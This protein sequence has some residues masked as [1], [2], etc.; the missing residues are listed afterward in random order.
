MKI[1][2]IQN[3]NTQYKTTLKKA[4]APLS[5][6]SSPQQQNSLSN[7]YYMPLNP[8]FNGLRFETNV[9][10]KVLG[11]N[12]Q[13]LGLYTP[14][15]NFIDFAKVGLEKLSKEPL[16]IV[17]A[18]AAEIIAYRF[19]LAL[20][21]SYAEGSESGSQWGS[22]YNPNNMT[23]PLAIGNSLT[24]KSAKKIF[25]NNLKFLQNPKYGKSLD[26][27]ITDKDGNLIINAIVFD[28][29]TTG[30]DIRDAKIVQ[31]ATSKIENGKVIKEA[32]VNQLINPEIPIPLEATAVHGI[33][34]SMVKDAP[35]MKDYIEG[36]LKNTINKENG[37]IV[38]Y[39]SKYDIPL[40]NREVREYNV[41]TNK[42]LKE[43]QMAKVLDPFILIQ[44]IHPFIGT[45][46]K[47]GVQYNWLFCKEMENAHDA[48][49]DVNGTVDVL[50]Y[51]LYYLSEHRKDKSVP[52]TLRE[53]LLFQNGETAIE[54]I[55]LPINE[56]KGFNKNVKF[57]Q[58]YRLEPLDVTNYFLKYK[59]SK[60]VITEIT[61]EIGEVNA[62]K[63][64]GEGFVN[65][66][67]AAKYKGHPLMAA[68]TQNIPDSPKAKSLKY[69]L[70]QNMREVLGFAKL[71]GYNGK[72]KE[73]ITDFI[74]EKSKMYL[75][76]DIKPIW[77]K[78]VN[79]ADMAKGNDLPDDAIAQKVMKEREEV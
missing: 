35:T 53:V 49:A 34:D 5:V 9:I 41:E 69:V 52:L 48:M 31:I 28:T 38:A 57:D 77:I 22:R 78:N 16:N 42:Q 23:S 10:Q 26:K 65:E 74:M 68:E 66:E 47:L 46:K 56:T 61:P 11:K 67:I 37:V 63:L 76:N 51:C 45:K 71:E 30:T 13:G 14:D 4:Q 73:E 19:A 21:E 62:K 55:A 32:N 27:P 75:N 8:R 59:L 64:L 60:K 2:P 7:V 33:T 43:R 50:K 58:S 12:Y 70:E 79:P 40:L 39:N 6:I 18:T 24:S 17:K 54:N 44:R 36:F 29:E 25:E 72:T 15:K 3:N 20:S 1:L